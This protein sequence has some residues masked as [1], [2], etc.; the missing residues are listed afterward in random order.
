M[1]KVL[2]VATVVK[3]HINVFH[4]PYLEWFKKNG[5]EVHVCARNDFEEDEIVNMEY[6]DRYYNMPFERNPLHPN[7]IKVYSK[8]RSIIKENEY[9]LIHCHTPTGG[10]ITRLA[11]KGQRK[12][13]TK[14][15]YTAHG[16]HF[17]KNAPKINWMIFYPVEKFLSRY[18]DV[19]I[20]IN[21]EDYKISNKMKAK[22]N[23]YVPGV[24]VKLKKFDENIDIE[25][26]KNELYL[27]PNKKIIL[28][29][30][31][32]SVRKNHKYAIEALNRLKREEFTYL[33]VGQGPLKFELENIADK[34]DLDVRF[35]G[36]RNDISEIMKISDLFVFPSLQE[37][38]P[39]ALMEAM[40]SGLPVVCSNI[41]GN[42][43]LIVNNKGGY[44]IE[45][46][47]IKGFSNKINKILNDKE[48]K[49]GDY[50]KIKVKE[51]DLKNVVNIMG[52]IYREELENEYE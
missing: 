26:K 52:T 17:F 20:T 50:N 29:V 40:A 1:K 9:D 6:V 35:L 5:Y 11:A 12:T 38:L 41:R 39:V 31:E 42:N 10:L 43:D 2:F 36:F 27:D 37:G 46:D 32:M 3:M 30:G 8:L 49:F 16:F 13:G 24:G 45:L 48:N 25:K 44:L 34:Y 18:T 28:S 14:V 7:N 47:N 15:L 19:L 4:I 22:R 23:E 51:F 33:I 21:S